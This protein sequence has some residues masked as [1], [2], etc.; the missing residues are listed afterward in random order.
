MWCIPPRL[1][2]RVAGSCGLNGGWNLGQNRLIPHG[3]V[4]RGFGRLGGTG[5]RGCAAMRQGGTCRALTHIGLLPRRRSTGRNSARHLTAEDA[6]FHHEIVGPANQNQMLRFVAAHQNELATL[7]HGDGVQHRETWR[8][9]ATADPAAT[10]KNALGQADQQQD[11]EDDHRRC[12]NHRNDRRQ[13]LTDHAGQPFTH[14]PYLR[15]AGGPFVVDVSG[16][17]SVFGSY[18]AARPDTGSGQLRPIL[19]CQDDVR[20]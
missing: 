13:I 5:G 3:G 18:V 14:S 16:P 12:Q 9:M 6:L 1:H 11:Q 10:G 2:H 15:D 4:M 17:Q 19:P 8:A 20:Q 7:V